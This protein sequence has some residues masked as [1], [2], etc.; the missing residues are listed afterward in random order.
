MHHG[1]QVNVGMA[2]LKKAKHGPL[3]DELT[4]LLQKQEIEDQNETLMSH[5]KLSLLF[6]FKEDEFDLIS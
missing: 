5:P 2:I 6:A 3:P 1:L 4:L